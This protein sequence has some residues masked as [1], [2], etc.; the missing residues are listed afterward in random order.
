MVCKRN[1]FLGKPGSENANWGYAPE[2]VAGMWQMLQRDSGDDFVLATN[3]THTVREFC[4]A[5]FRAM[6]DLDWK[7]FVKHDPRLRTS[8]RSRHSYR[9]C[10]QSEKRFWGGKAKTRFNDLVRLNGGCRYGIARAQ[11]GPRTSW[12]PAVIVKPEAMVCLADGF[13]G[14][15]LPVANL[16]KRQATRPALQ[17]L[18]GQDARWPHSQDGCATRK[19]RLQP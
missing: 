10:R 12:R 15:P 6:V 7:E 19:R 16:R 9:E 4:E 5:A 18:N 17:S 11:N 8:G 1:Y 2:Y 14:Q 3:E 13:V